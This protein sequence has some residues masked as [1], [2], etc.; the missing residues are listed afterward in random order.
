MLLKCDDL[1]INLQLNVILNVYFEDGT[2]VIILFVL[3]EDVFS[4]K[5]VTAYIFLLMGEGI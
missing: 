3:T 2:F 1:N 5:D 4:F